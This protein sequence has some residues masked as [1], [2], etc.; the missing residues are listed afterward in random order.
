MMP[1]WPRA[2]LTLPSFEAGFDAH[3][4][5]DDPSQFRQ[6]GLLKLCLG[7]TGWREVIGI[8]ILT[9][10]L[11]GLRRGFLLQRALVREGTTGDD[12]PL[13]GSRPFTFQPRLHAAL[14]HCNL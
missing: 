2:H 9:V 4:R 12:Q 7:P 8:A 10:L 6:R 11:R 14:D 13:R 5:F 1:A 3:S